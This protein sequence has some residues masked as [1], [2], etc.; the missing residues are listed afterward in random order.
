[1]S[2]T[3]TPAPWRE[4]IGAAGEGAIDMHA[5]AG[6]RL[7]DAGRRDVFG[8]V[9]RFEPRHDD[10]LMPAASAP[11]PRRGRSAVPFLSTSAPW[12]MVCTVV[13]PIAPLARPL[14]IS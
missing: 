8:D 13:P 3:S 10:S 4:Q 9:A 5:L 1:L 7:R 11:R 12:R 2:T 6:D 14:R